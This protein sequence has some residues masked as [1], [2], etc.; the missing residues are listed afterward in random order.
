M[1]KIEGSQ[2]SSLA[3]LLFVSIDHF[4]EKCDL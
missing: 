2:V 1:F 4:E 3:L